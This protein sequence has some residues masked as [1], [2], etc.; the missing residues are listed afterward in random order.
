MWNLK[1]N[2]KRDKVLLE[3][4]RTEIS[5]ARENGLLQVIPIKEKEKTELFSTDDRIQD[6]GTIASILFRREPPPQQYSPPQQ[7]PQTQQYSPPQQDPESQKIPEAIPISD[8][9]MMKAL[10]PRKIP[11]YSN[12]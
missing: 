12:I 6:I 4:I 7:R 5:L 10:Y 8:E 11:N 3:K 9:D 1:A 2:P